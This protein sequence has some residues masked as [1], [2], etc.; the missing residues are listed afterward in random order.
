MFF[1][2]KAQGG[3]RNI[4][5]FLFPGVVPA[6]GKGFNIVTLR[7]LFQIAPWKPTDSISLRVSFSPGQ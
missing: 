4:E 5:D 7:L 3:I 2:P 6:G 1:R